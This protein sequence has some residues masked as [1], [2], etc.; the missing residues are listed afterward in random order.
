MATASKDEKQTSCVPAPR[1]GQPQVT[2]A[3]AVAAACRPRHQGPQHLQVFSQ[4]PRLAVHLRH[5]AQPGSQ[6]GVAGAWGH[7]PQHRIHGCLDL[8]GQGDVAQAGDTCG[9]QK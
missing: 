4:R 7:R 2:W 3:A 6:L 1:P 9:Q 5:Q 8:R